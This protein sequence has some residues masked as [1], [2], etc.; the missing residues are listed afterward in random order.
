M[1]IIN[2][3]E[4]YKISYI[5]EKDIQKYISKI[6]RYHNDIYK[7]GDDWISRYLNNRNIKKLNKLLYKYDIVVD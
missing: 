3:T 1:K 7:F 5:N 4:L 2:Q 6:N